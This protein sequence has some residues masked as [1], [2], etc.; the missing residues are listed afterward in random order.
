[1]YSPFSEGWIYHCMHQ[2]D[3]HMY[4]VVSCMSVVMY[5]LL[6]WFVHL[7]GVSLIVLAQPYLSFPI[8]LNFPIADSIANVLTW[9]TV[10]LSCLV[11]HWAG[12]DLNADVASLM[13]RAMARQVPLLSEAPSQVSHEAAGCKPVS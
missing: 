7:A 11:L 12:F 8:E 5:I 13:Y 9:H 10:T 1:M 2:L 3:A 4:R 6:F